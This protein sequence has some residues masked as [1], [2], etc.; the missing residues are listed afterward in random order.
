MS[1]NPKQD[2]HE[3]AH[4][5]T[6]VSSDYHF[7]PVFQSPSSPYGQWIHKIMFD[8]LDL[9]RDH[10]LVDIGCGSGT[11]CLWLL[12][13]MNNEISV[14]G[15]DISSGMIEIF[16]NET[17]QRNLTKLVKTF[18]MD[19]VSFSQQKQL[20]AYHRIFFKGII[21]LLSPSERILAFKG[22]YQQLNSLDNKLVIFGRPSKEIFPLDKRT[23]EIFISMTPSFDTYVSE[24]EMCGFTNIQLE[25]CQ[26]TF[27]DNITLADWINVIQKRLWSIF[28]HDKINEEQ[29][30][31][32]ISYL[33]ETY[34]NQKFQLKDEFV[35]LHCTAE[36][37]PHHHSLYSSPS[38][39][40]E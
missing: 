30:A 31:E 32:C 7:D 25:T 36:K 19:A 35:I 29:M 3:V 13:K 9:K 5:F 8:A 11:D 1:T 38:S 18:C 34:K 14:I 4:H 10:I 37:Q 12:N 17:K 39:V 24:L 40:N 20:P 22:F 28:S 23:Q 26:Y 2:A 33:H 21:H 16:D 6:N 15:N 27:D